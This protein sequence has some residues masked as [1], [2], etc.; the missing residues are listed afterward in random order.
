MR[1]VLKKTTNDAKDCF[2][3]LSETQ[4]QSEVSVIHFSSVVAQSATL[5]SNSWSTSFWPWLSHSFSFELL[6]NCFQT[7]TV[8]SVNLK[9][10][11]DG[12]N[13]QVRMIYFLDCVTIIDLSNPKYL[14]HVPLVGSPGP[15]Q[16]K[17]IQEKHDD[18]KE[19]HYYVPCFEH[20][21]ESSQYGAVINWIWSD[22]HHWTKCCQ[23]C[24]TAMG[25]CD[26]CQVTNLKTHEKC[27][28]NLAVKSEDKVH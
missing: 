10:Y 26:T 5:L 4:L 21:T 13:S 19:K 11:F 14:F 27:H 17:S 1:L 6:G 18:D 20:W 24:A 2:H 22:V 7:I 28:L 25:T 12:M 16:R 23:M 9:A 15:H 3:K 8:L